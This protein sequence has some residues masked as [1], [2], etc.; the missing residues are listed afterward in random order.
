MFTV[1]VTPTPVCGPVTA[2]I[3]HLHKEFGE[4]YVDARL[5]PNGHAVVLVGNA[6]TGTWSIL[7]RRPTGEACVAR[8]GKGFFMPDFGELV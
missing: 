7:Y 8:T 5:L 6:I 4:T 1:D 2:I 3:Q